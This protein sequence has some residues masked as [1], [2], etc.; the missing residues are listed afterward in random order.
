MLMERFRLDG[1]AAIVTGAGRGIGRAIAVAL[2]EAGAAVACAART[3]AEIASAAEDVIR[4]GGKA[5]AVPCDVDDDAQLQRLVTEAVRAFGRLDVLVNNAGGAPPCLALA[6][7]REEF[8]A[9][10][11]FNVG[12][13]FTLSR[14]ALP[15]LLEREGASIVNV[16]SA[17]SHLV[18]SGFVSYGTAKAALNHMTRLLAC[19]FA[20]RVRCNAIAPGAVLTEA[21]GLFVTGELREQME[22]RTPLRR[23]GT[24]QDIAATALYLA[25]PASSWVT[26]KVFEIDGGTVDSNWPIKFNAL[27]AL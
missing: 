5:I 6:V 7:T 1:K 16:S 12:S 11:R 2:G 4:A 24:P 27:D 9:A 17:M 10:F 26:G 13:A 25:S 23:L 19:E 18:D 14:F 22:A 15:H 21:L 3:Q 20:P 8:E